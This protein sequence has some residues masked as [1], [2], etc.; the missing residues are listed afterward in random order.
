MRVSDGGGY[1]AITG[2]SY[3]IK[4]APVTPESATQYS[5]AQIE[6]MFSTLDPEAASQAGG[7]HTQAGRTL[8]DIA[9]SLVQHAQKLGQNWTG[10]AAQSAVAAFQQL[11]ETAVGLSQASAQTGAVLTWLGDTI[12]PFYKSYQAP[13]N[14]VVGDVESLF[15]DNPQDKAAQ[16]V[17]ERLNNRLVQANSNLPPSVTKNLPTSFASDHT[18]ATTNNVGSGGAGAGQAAGGLGGG[19]GSGPVHLDGVGGPAGPGG[20]GVAGTVGGLKGGSPGSVSH[21]AGSAPP[22]G[23]SAGTGLPG[24]GGPGAGAPVTTGGGPGGGGVIPFGGLPGGPGAGAGGL[25]AEGLGAESA[26]LGSEG[27][28]GDGAIGV[29]PGDGVFIGSDGMIGMTPGGPGAGGFGAAENMGVTQA[30]RVGFAQ[31][32]G[33]G[34]G[35]EG[36]GPAAAGGFGDTAAA[37]AA[38]ADGALA[39]EAAGPGMAGFPMAGAGAGGRDRE[40]RRQSW[41]TEDADVWAS[42]ADVVSAQ[43]GA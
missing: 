6:E 23:G 20:P 11:H 27:L 1:G 4:T 12:L 14:G 31:A 28:I 9:D 26:G 22:P 36:F 19:G 37:G 43:I 35:E 39:G 40:R 24:G 16:A 8:A 3:H 15:G 2:S 34:F 42:Q 13:G 17:M 10:T 32:E 5:A 38:G 25:G 33:L 30:E 18:S 21:L 41:M 29:P 7:A